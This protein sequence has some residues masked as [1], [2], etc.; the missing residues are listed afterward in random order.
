MS[1]NQMR[2]RFVSLRCTLC[3]A[4]FPLE[5]QGTC[6]RCSGILTGHYDLKG[7]TFDLKYRGHSIWQYRDMMP[8]VSDSSIISMGEGWTPLV[9]ARRYGASIGADLWCKVEGENPSGSFKDRAASLGISLAESWHKTGVYTASS[10]NAA[11]AVSAYA[12]RAGMDCIVLVREDSTPS[13]LGQIAMYG[14]RLLR[15]RD[16][17]RTRQTLERA[18]NLMQSALPSWLNHFVWAPYNPLLI[19]GLK[20]VAYEIATECSGNSLPD[21]IYVPTAGGDL[22]YGIFKVFQ[23]LRAAGVVERV[24]RMVV[25]QGLNASPSVS[26][27]ESGSKVVPE[28]ETADTIAGA[29]RVNFGAEHTLLAVRE[30]GGFGVAVSDEEIIS[31]QR[32]IA[33]MDG[34][35]TEVSSA[36]ALAAIAKSAAEGKIQKD[37]RVLA[38]LTGSGFKDYSPPFK[39]ISSVPLAESAD[40]IPSI[41]ESKFGL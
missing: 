1:D 6:A 23:E 34:I 35:F 36:T 30:S 15:V 20:T 12:A 41:L 31:A 33:A 18:F 14:P 10:G 2:N 19:D 27:I 8:P 32:K 29:L 21:C 13:K 26:A 7:K 11:A 16:I 9:P 3:G 17:F 40:Q 24:P 28:I 37:D 5:T 25:A 39:D 22:L 4:E 38:I